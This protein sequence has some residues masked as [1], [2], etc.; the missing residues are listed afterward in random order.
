[1]SSKSKGR[2]ESATR[3]QRKWRQNRKAEWSASKLC[4]LCGRPRVEGRFYCSAC[5]LDER[6]RGERRR[7][8][9]SG[10]GICVKCGQEYWQA[11]I[12]PF[13]F[14]YHGTRGCLVDRVRLLRR[15]HWRGLKKLR[16]SVLDLLLWAHFFGS[17]FGYSVAGQPK[18]L[19]PEPLFTDEEHNLLVAERQ[20]R[21]LRTKICV[22]PFGGPI[23]DPTDCTAVEEIDLGPIGARDFLERLEA[24]KQRMKRS[25]RARQS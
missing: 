4:V 3:R 12:F 22:H 17:G 7:Q 23:H 20:R 6:D 15:A 19:L 8:N 5:L 1:M 13:D 2:R 21:G 24:A 11:A 18:L 14:N 16:D 9:N 10:R 25:G